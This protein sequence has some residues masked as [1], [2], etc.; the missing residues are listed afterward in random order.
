MLA[1]ELLDFYTFAQTNTLVPLKLDETLI[2]I[3]MELG[4]L[5]T[6]KRRMK[7]VIF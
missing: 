6:N 7:K 5:R 2:T 1:G 3:C 4:C